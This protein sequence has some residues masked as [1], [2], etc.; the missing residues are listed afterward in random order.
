MLSKK[1]AKKARKKASEAASAAAVAEGEAD[2]EL[3]L[4][5]LGAKANAADARRAHIE[6][7]WVVESRDLD[8]EAE[9][10]RRFGASSVRAAQR[11][12]AQEARRGHQQLEVRGGRG[13][14]RPAPRRVLLVTPKADWGR[15]H[16]LYSMGVRPHPT[17]EGLQ[18]FQFDYSAEAL[19]LNSQFEQLVLASAD[20]QML[21]ELLRAQPCHVGALLQLHAVATQTGQAELSAEFLLRA[22]WAHEA[23]VHPTFAAAWLRGDA[24]LF[25]AHPPNRPFFR[26]LHLHAVALARR[27]CHKAAVAVAT[28]LLSLERT[29]PTH[30][31]LWLD[32]FALKAGAPHLLVRFTAAEPD[33]CI[34]L[35]GWMLSRALALRLLAESPPPP[36][37]REELLAAATVDVAPSAAGSGDGG[38]GGGGSKK[39]PPPVPWEG[40]GPD[41]ALRAALLT[42]PAMLSAA[43]SACNPSESSGAMQ[44]AAR[45]EAAFPS[46]ANAALEHLTVLYWERCTELWARPERLV[47]L[48]SVA[49]GLLDK[50]E[51][52]RAAAAGAAGSAKKA[53]GTA[54]LQEVAACSACT[55]R[56]YPAGGGDPLRGCELEIN[57]E[58]L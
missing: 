43:L 15:S 53:A 36:E 33:A 46:A 58:N 4:L 38:G 52:A 42:F 12:A 50:V 45:W 49:S 5:E 22:L 21:M 31:F 11:E 55:E 24:K 57:A 17:S 10:R 40:G 44:L 29:D 48:V 30:V 47:W 25:H 39:R 37:M 23:S 54:L 14:R 1:A 20:P 56:W 16:G 9:M 13:G 26:A 7:V 8:G 18:L 27:G 3:Q 19:A 51:A 41:S 28:L 2:E 6:S 35:P 34:R 32:L